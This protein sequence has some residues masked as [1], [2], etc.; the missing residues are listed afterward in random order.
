[1]NKFLE[2]VAEMVGDYD[3]NKEQH[4]AYK[5]SRSNNWAGAKVGLAALAGSPFLGPVG[6]VGAGYLMNKRQQNLALKDIGVKK[7]LKVEN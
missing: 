6:M 1:M 5:K 7:P 3:L 2:K 4:E